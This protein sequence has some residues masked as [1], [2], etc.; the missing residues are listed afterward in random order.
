MENNYFQMTPLLLSAHIG[1]FYTIRLK[2]GIIRPYLLIWASGP[3]QH[4][5]SHGSTDG[6]TRS[7]NT[8]YIISSLR[9]SKA[10]GIR[11]MGFIPLIVYILL[12]KNITVLGSPHVFD[13]RILYQRFLYTMHSISVLGKEAK[14]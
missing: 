12:G 3:I 7:V 5:L 14:S 11:Y 9:S 10:V 6:S 8:C 1:T 2:Y 4:S 13:E